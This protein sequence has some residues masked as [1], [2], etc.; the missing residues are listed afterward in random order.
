MAARLVEIG[1]FS[2]RYRGYMLPVA[3][4]LLLI[5]SPD[6]APDP[7]TVGIAGFCVALF[8]QLIRI[9]TIGFDYI[10]RGGKNH[11]VY[12]EKLVT[13][14]AYSL[15]RNP[16]YVGNFFLLIGL[17]LASNSWLF[18]LVGVPLS[19]FMHR[20]IIAAEENFLRNKFGPQFEEYC[21]T[22]P[23][24]LPK[25]SGWGRAFAGM[26]F[27]WTR[28]LA[29]EYFT[30]FDYLAAVAIVVMANLWANDRIDQH[31]DLF[32]LMVLV[33][34]VRLILWSIGSRL[35]K[36]ETAV[37]A[38][39][40]VLLAVCLMGSPADAAELKCSMSFSMKGW[41]AFY[42]T[43]SGKGTIS[44]NNGKKM[45]VKL[46]AKGGGLTVGKST[47]DNGRGEFSSVA[48]VDELLGSY[49]SAEAHAGAVKSSQAQVMTKGE[50]SLALSGEGRGWDLGVAFGK[51][52]ISK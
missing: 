49:V 36:R 21:A 23:R 33:I 4:I 12:A 17:A 41:S 14:G 48:S 44:C 39:V 11:K 19:L 40:V 31:R 29:K 37:A 46:S 8:G 42:K 1:D 7:A 5:P 15:V 9:G 16:M 35:K 52:T 38:S 45:N 20:A 22:V 30:P 6:L 26:H 32:V 50:V 13:G 47:I 43:A 51:L 25:L 24:W 3:I 2:F 34:V 18:V 10:I 28:V 27:N